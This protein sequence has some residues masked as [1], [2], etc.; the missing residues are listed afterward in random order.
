M[1]FDRLAFR[2]AGT[3]DFAKLFTW[4][5]QMLLQFI[6]FWPKQKTYLK[7]VLFAIAMVFLIFIN[8]G[9]AVEFSSTFDDL[10]RFV[11]HVTYITVTVQGTAKTLVIYINN[12]ELEVILDD[13]MTKFWPYD[14]LETKLKKELKSFYYVIVIIMISLVTFGVLYSSMIMITPWASRKFPFDVS[15]PNIDYNASPYYE[16][17]YLVQIFTI[18]YFLFCLVLGCDYSF[19]AICSCVI[20]QYK[21]LQN[22]LM[23]FHT[24][25][26]EEVN[27]KLRR[28]GNDGLEGKMY[29]IHKEYFIR[30]VN[31]HHLLLGITKKMNS[32]FSSIEMVQL[33]CSMTGVCIGLFSLTA[34]EDPPVSSL[35]IILSFTAIYFNELFVY[36][37][38]GNELHYQASFLPEFV[39]KSNWNELADKE[40]TRDFMFML[41]RSQDIPQLSAYNLYDINMESYIKVFKLSFSFYTFLTTM[42]EK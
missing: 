40:L 4:I 7:T 36:C 31:H 32:M 11:M 26:M 29:P 38:I 21:L 34:L 18:Q 37:A 12:G 3:T 14:L 13:I 1:F 16:L 5:P 9:L 42:K 41:Q 2:V 17:I 15:Y 8:V 23:A 6:F 35:V 24:P 27:R 39:F 22:A 20:A 30:C 33:S 25:L 19:L 10:V 28:I